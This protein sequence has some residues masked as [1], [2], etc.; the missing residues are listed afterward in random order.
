MSRARLYIPGGCRKKRRAS[1]SWIARWLPSGGVQAG[2]SGHRRIGLDP[3]VSG[4][5]ALSS[6]APTCS[7]QHPRQPS[8]EHIHRHLPLWSMKPVAPMRARQASPRVPCLKDPKRQRGG[9]RI[10]CRRPGGVTV[11]QVQ[12]ERRTGPI[13]DVLRA[14]VGGARGSTTVPL[15]TSTCSQPSSGNGTSWSPRTEASPSRSGRRQDSV[16]TEY[17][18]PGT[19][20]PG[21]IRQRHPDPHHGPRVGAQ[22]PILVRSTLPPPGVRR[23]AWTAPAGPQSTR[24]APHRMA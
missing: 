13:R 6:A 18:P 1:P 17:R 2:R 11:H 12:G 22:R 24:A 16:G 4:S 5:D 15:G 10:R 9:L 3:S 19:H 14:P 23:S 21:R 7:P 8:S 20:C